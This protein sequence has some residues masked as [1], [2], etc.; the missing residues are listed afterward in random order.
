MVFL[1]TGP[2]GSINRGYHYYRQDAAG[3][4]SVEDAVETSDA[5]SSVLRFPRAALTK[6]DVMR[7]ALW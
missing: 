4:A 3:N 7:M 6:S 5:F 1:S 2:G